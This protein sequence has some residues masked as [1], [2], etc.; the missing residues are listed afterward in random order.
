MNGIVT[1]LARAIAGGNRKELQ[2]V[3]TNR[4][5]V[6]LIREPF[7]GAWQRNI[8]EN[9]DSVLS[10]GP[11]FACQ[12]LIA[13]DIAKMRCRV[14]ELGEEGIWTEADNNTA[15][16]P[17]LRKPNHYQNRIQF[18]ET[19]VL[20]KLSRGNAYILK[21][22]DARGVVQRLYPL[23]PTRVRPL[24]SAS[25]EVFYE[26]HKDPLS[27]QMEDSTVVPAREIIHDRFN[28]LFHPLVGLSPLFA[29]TLSASQGL[30]IQRN[31]SKFWQ[32][33]ARPSGVLT[34][35]GEINQDTADRLKEHW[36]TNFNGDN[37]ARI[38]V[39]GDG[40]K[41]EP[42]T[43]TSVDAQ[44][45][46][47]LGVT[48]KEV[49]SVYHVPAYKIGAAEPPSF[50][51]IEALDRA[52]YSQCLQR[53]VEDVELCLDE[54]LE[55]PTSPRLLGAEFDLDDLLRMDQSTQ[56]KTWAEG[57]KGGLVKPN[58]GRRKL[59]MGPTPGG[60]T[61]Y[62]Q[63]QNYSLEAL[64]K[65][66]AQEDPFKGAAVAQPPEP[67]NDEEEERRAA[68]FVADYRKHLTEIFDAARR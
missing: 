58:E 25:G 18:F 44:L 52:Y 63:Q 61:V 9:V 37:I 27:R 5:W 39:L 34:A 48:A 31:S 30:R 21:A 50:N 13:S 43:M 46:E 41:Y 67:A 40:L 2:A 7:T 17:V 20:S 53:H 19:W 68:A 65:R 8:D 60:D 66:D 10:F 29:A 4:G 38:A 51:N 59:G 62:L 45:V 15:H 1:T 3:D 33:G 26:L 42:M 47:Q 32:N 28:C 64:A 11:V 54:G 23:D 49:A 12:T 14:V 22:R 56:I 55:F 16:S 36:E 6:S 57:V 24:V 35:P